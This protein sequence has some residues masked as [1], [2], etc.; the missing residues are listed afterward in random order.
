MKRTEV[1]AILGILSLSSPALSQT[2][3]DE[4]VMVHTLGSD[5]K[6]SFGFADRGISLQKGPL[7]PLSLRGK[8]DAMLQNMGL[9]PRIVT[10]QK[11]YNGLNL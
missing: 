10:R 11:S 4:K 3:A 7:R 6:T 1:L 9:H 2:S 5:Q 8:T